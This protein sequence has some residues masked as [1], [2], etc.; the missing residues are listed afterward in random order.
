MCYEEA[1]WQI[2][3]RSFRFLPPS[4]TRGPHHC[5]ILDVSDN[6]SKFN[7]ALGIEARGFCIVR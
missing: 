4:A 1:R 6:R 2:G 7:V 3:G 5:S